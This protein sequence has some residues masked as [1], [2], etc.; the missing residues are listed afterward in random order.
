MLIF[1]SKAVVERRGFR[2]KIFDDCF[3]SGGYSKRSMKFSTLLLSTS[4]LREGNRKNPYP[5]CF[6]PVS[7]AAMTVSMTLTRAKY[8]S[9]AATIVQGATGVLVRATM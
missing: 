8:L 1:N 5:R 4:G 9:F 3:S 2:P 7:I 6:K